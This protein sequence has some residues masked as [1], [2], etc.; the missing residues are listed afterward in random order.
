MAK[1]IFEFLDDLTVKKT[2][3]DNIELHEW[4]AYSTFMMNR[5]ISMD[6][7]LVEIVAETQR[8]TATISPVL[9]YLF[10]RDI[11]PKKKLYLKYIKSQRDPEDKLSGVVNLL[12]SKLSISKTEAFEYVTILLERGEKERLIEFVESA[13]FTS[14]EAKKMVK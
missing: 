12:A 8:Y 13:G 11:L 7:N 4:K 10:Y 9:N 5:W 3:T 1:T 6:P 2:P 14:A